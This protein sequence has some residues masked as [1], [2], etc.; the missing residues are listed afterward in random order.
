MNLLELAERCEA[1][2]GPDR[3][4]SIEITDAL[5]PSDRVRGY[6][7]YTASVDAALSLVPEGYDALDLKFGPRGAD[8]PKWRAIV[9]MPSRNVGW[10][11]DAATPALALCAAAL[12]ARSE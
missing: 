11:A 8:E 3:D 4:L 2:T 5:D 6:P 10:D 12:R 1:A 7:D 9:W